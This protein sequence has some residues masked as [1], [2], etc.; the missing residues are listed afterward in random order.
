MGFIFQTSP[1][2]SNS[3]R[4]AVIQLSLRGKER[5]AINSFS[6]KIG[7]EPVYRKACEKIIEAKGLKSQ[8][9][10]QDLMESL[11]DFKPH[12]KITEI[13]NSIETHYFLV[14]SKEE[15]EASGDLNFTR[16]LS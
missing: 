8:R 5:S 11:H 13:K 10:V 4:P 9:L 7:I 16:H 6:T 3:F 14:T 15:R 12:Y 2:N 1:L